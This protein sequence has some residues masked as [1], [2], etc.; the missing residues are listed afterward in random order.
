[1]NS[2]MF[3]KFQSRLVIFGLAGLLLAVPLLGFAPTTYAAT[4]SYGCATNSILSWTIF[5]GVPTNLNLLGAYNPSGVELAQIL[6]PFGISPGPWPNGTADYE[7]SASNYITSNSNYTQWTFNVKP[8]LKWSNGEPL[9]ASTLLQNF[10]PTFALNA[11][12]DPVGASSWVT[13]EYAANS[14]EAVFVLNSSQ[15]HF[16]EILAP[17]VDTALYPPAFIA[18]GNTYSG[19][20]NGT[21][22]TDGPWYLKSYQTGSTTAVLLRNPYWNPVSPICEV[23]VNFVEAESMT[24]TSLLS[25]ASDFARI[26]PSAVADINATGH[27]AIVPSLVGAS[28]EMNLLYNITT[29]PFNQLQFRQAMLYAIN[30]TDIQ[31]N[32]FFGWGSPA[33]TMQGEVPN[34]TSS[35]W[36]DANQMAYSYNP[37]MALSLLHSL[38]FTTDSSGTLHYPN[39]TAVSFSFYYQTNDDSAILSSSIIANNFA[40]IGIRLNSEGVTNHQIRQLAH[41]GGSLYAVLYLSSSGGALFGSAYWD[42]QPSCAV[43]NS[44]WPCPSPGQNMMGNA[45]ANAEYWSNVSA[46]INTNVVSQEQKDLNNIQLL[47]AQWLPALNLQLGRDYIWAINDQKFT[48]LGPFEKAVAFYGE[49][50]NPVELSQ[51]TPVGVTTSSSTLTTGVTSPSASTSTTTMQS[52]TTQSSSTTTSQGSSTLLYIAIAVVV[53]VVIGAIAGILFSRRG[54]QASA[55]PGT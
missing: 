15:P 46:V 31:Q 16:A 29:Y 2:N 19:L 9:N 28:G 26:D 10:G 51:I 49:E 53:I 37:T 54:R 5:G 45:T 4:D 8:G 13:R 35:Q 47:R 32:G 17:T 43:Y 40:A 20:T 55:S 48:N 14:S 34:V 50:L 1:M 33:Y 23:D 12:V 30:Q 18:Q 11:S 7:S 3:G 39:G 6:Y 52:S 42:A 21:L 38:G 36:Y 27:F 22:V 24:P 41:Q 25:S 44:E